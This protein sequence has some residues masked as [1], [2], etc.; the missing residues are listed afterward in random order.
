MTDPWSPNEIAA[1]YHFLTLASCKT[2]PEAFLK[3]VEEEVVGWTQKKR[4]VEGLRP[5]LAKIEVVEQKLS[6]IKAVGKA[7]H[8]EEDE[9]HLANT[10]ASNNL[11][12]KIAAVNSSIQ[13]QTEEGRITSEERPT[14]LA[15][16]NTRKD[17]A[18]AENKEKV[19]EKLERNIGIVSKLKPYQLPIANIMGIHKLNR[20]LAEVE[21]L[22]KR[23]SKSLSVD[24]HDRVEKKGKLEE[25][26]AETQRKSRLWF[27]GEFEFKARL[28]RCLQEFIKNEEEML[29]K[30]QEEAWE[31]EREEERKAVEEK[32]LAAERKREEE[33]KKLLEKLEA[34]RKEDEAKPKKSPPLQPKKAPKPKGMKID[35][36]LLF[37]APAE[38]RRKEELEREKEEIRR[39]EEEGSA[40]E[41]E[42]EEP[43][44][45][46]EGA[47]PKEPEK[48]PTASTG[49]YPAS[50]PAPPAAAAPPKAE[51]KPK[52]KPVK[53]VLEN[54]W[55]DAPAAP[56][57]SG[58][59]GEEGEAT[60]PSLAEAVKVEA[61]VKEVKQKQPP[62][63]PKKKG[64][65]KKF[66]KMSVNELG[67]EANNPNYN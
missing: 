11:K 20:S 43:V 35:N 55:G 21:A 51:A 29:R 26:I 62:P 2:T 1:D 64:E 49:G 67:F 6:V 33:A 39:R 27:E 40:S 53:V 41:A 56:A 30:E 47:K 10:Y 46:K 54:K 13:Q 22:E 44:P 9:Q 24:Q 5:L 18:K 17:K 52:P 38:L 28:S 48:P 60:G 45:A 63:E 16:L 32:R 7:K 36:N 19:L 58:D 14:V 50:A 12:E 34:K 66:T 25:E 65:K 4:L 23:P 3:T 15:Q 59:E 8:L 57:H 37:V 31:R 42:E 61:P